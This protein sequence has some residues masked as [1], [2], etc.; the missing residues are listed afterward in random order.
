M[1]EL[2]KILIVLCGLISCGCCSISASMSEA[3]VQPGDNITIYCDCKVSTGKYVVWFRNCS[4]EYQPTLVVD[5]RNAVSSPFTGKTR[6]FKFVKNESSNSYDL[7]IRNV[8]NSDEGLYY[9]GTLENKV[10]KDENK[11]IF[12]KEAYI[13]G[14]L[15]TRITLYTET[16]L[17]HPN[18]SM[19]VEECGLCW[20][21]L[22]SLCP[23]VSAF[24]ALLLVYLLCQNPENI[25][26]KKKRHGTS[27]HTEETQDNK[28]CCAALEICQASGSQKKNMTSQNSEFSMFT[29]VMYVM[30]VGEL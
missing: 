18:I 9:C 1:D 12:S 21:L 3:T 13:Y 27:R 10:E 5:W 19:T 7:M 8:T 2:L 6:R 23:T 14:N 28:V 26:A 11:N 17:P 16:H 22:L 20:N 15:T 4:H 25:Q 29:T 30:K 24:S